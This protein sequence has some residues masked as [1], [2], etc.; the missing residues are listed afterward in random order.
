MKIYSR[1]TRAATQTTAGGASALKGQN[2]KDVFDLLRLKNAHPTQLEVI[3]ELLYKKSYTTRSSRSSSR[4]S[5]PPVQVSTSLQPGMQ[6]PA[7][8]YRQPSGTWRPLPT[9]PIQTPPPTQQH[10]ET[11]FAKPD[12]LRPNPYLAD[13]TEVIDDDTIALNHEDLINIAP[14]KRAQYINLDHNAVPT[15]FSNPAIDLNQPPVWDLPFTC[16]QQL[17]YQGNFS[18]SAALQLAQEMEDFT[19]TMPDHVKTR[20][21]RNTIRVLTVH[22]YGTPR[23]RPI[24]PTTRWHGFK[25][26]WTYVNGSSQFHYEPRKEVVVLGDVCLISH[27][28][29][30]HWDK[31]DKQTAARNAHMANLAASTVDTDLRPASTYAPFPTVSA[32]PGAQQSWNIPAT[33]APSPPL[34]TLLTATG[35]T[36]ATATSPPSAAPAISSSSV[37]TAASDSTTA[38]DQK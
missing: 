38:M 2:S 37:T 13:S 30:M 35:T 32:E 21:R 9:I 6:L 5:T 20:C 22:N 18:Q 29:D 19:S 8:R 3:F 24:E 31:E 15:R 25:E 23:L 14:A 27:A 12:P 26:R 28:Y 33:L 7:Q 34:T 1:P 17:Y 36:T 16:A 11:D 10:Q 4:G